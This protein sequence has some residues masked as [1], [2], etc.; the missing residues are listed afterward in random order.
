MLCERRNRSFTKKMVQDRVR[1][2]ERRESL[3]SSLTIT[4]LLI[5][6]NSFPLSARARASHSSSRRP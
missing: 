1:W 3:M 2:A 4:W 6:S 5:P